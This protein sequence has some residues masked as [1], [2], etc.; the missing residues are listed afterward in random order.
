[1]GEL[2]LS[3]PNGIH[4]RLTQ[5]ALDREISLKKLIIDIL[6]GYTGHERSEDNEI[7]KES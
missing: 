4:K 7:K 6:E 3:I 5:K 2:R 1:M